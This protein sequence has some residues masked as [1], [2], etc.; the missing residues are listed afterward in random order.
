MPSPTLRSDADILRSIVIAAGLCWSIVFV[1]VAIQYELQLF[2][3]GAMF[4]YAVAVQDVWAFH[5]HNISARMSVFFL[6]LWPA[7]TFVGLTGSPRGGIVVYGILFYIAPLLGLIGTFAAD[8]SRGR[9]LF[10]YACCSTAVLCPLVF[11]FPTEMWLAHALFWPT[12]AVSQYANRSLGGAALVFTMIAA[13]ALTHEGALVLSFGIVSTLALRGLRDGVFLRAVGVLISVLI[14]W[15]AVKLLYPPGDYFAVVLRRAALHFFDLAVFEVRIVSLLLAT[16]AGY[17]FVYLVL[18]RFTTGNII[19]YAVTAIVIALGVYWLWLD[20][21]VHAS[22]R[23]YLRT[24]LVIFTPAFGALAGFFA[25]RADKIVLTAP[26]LEQAIT[27]LT[28]RGTV[29]A[30]M[31]A[32]LLVTLVYAVE[33]AKFAVA[34]KEYRTVFAALATSSA[35]DPALGDPHFISSQRISTD[36]NRLTWFSTTPYL[37]VLVAGFS[38][39]RLVVDPR[40]NYFWLSCDTATANYKALRAVPAESRNLIRIYS[41][42]HR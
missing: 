15:M 42:L 28:N 41:C 20:H 39:N 26:R 27:K 7:E 37:S 24:M 3:D 33:T 29:S 4:S 34:W 36:L 25:M 19:L 17:T 13:L 32:F 40:A 10:V 16:L 11:G 22:N 14:I 12:L 9:I 31:G 18:L 2:A 30:L 35:S 23:Y 1:A 6:T 38:P 21:S 8:R 5:W